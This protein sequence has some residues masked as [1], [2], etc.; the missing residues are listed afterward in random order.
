MSNIKHLF[1]RILYIIIFLLGSLNVMGQITL[2]IKNQPLKKVI[3]Q[4]EKV[5]EYRFFYNNDLAD[6]NKSVTLVAQNSNIETVLK[7][8]ASQTSFSYLIKPNFQIVLSD[9][10]PS[11]QTKLQDITGRV[12]DA[13]GIPIIG[14]NVIVKGTTNGVITDIDGNFS[15]EKVPVK[16]LLQ[17]SYIGYET[18]ELAVALGKT[19]VKVVM[20]ENSKLLNEVVVT[21]FGLAQ[22]KATLTGAIASVG[23]D[24]ISRSSAVNTSGALV[25]K[26]AGLNYRSTDSRPGNATTLQIRNMGTPLFVIDGVQSDEGQFNNIDFNDIES[27]S[28]LKDAS[29]SIYGVRAANGVIVVT[30]KKGQKNSKSTV[31]LNTYYGIQ[32]VSRLQKPADAVTYVENYIQSETIQGKTSRLYNKE[33]LEKW[34]QGTE[35]GY[36]PFDWYDYIWVTSPQYYVNA[37]V[38]GG[39]DKINYYF[40]LGHMNQESAIRNYGGMKRY[41]IQMNI[42][43]QITDKFKIGMNMNGRIK[44]LK[45]PGVPGSDDYSNPTAATYRNLPTVRPFANDN[46]NYPASVGSDSGLN[47]GLLNFEK[48]GVFEDTWRMAQLNLNA[49]YEIIKGLKAKALFG[50]YFASELLNNQEYTYRVYR[51]DEATDEYVDV[52]GR[53]SAWRERTNAQVEELTSNIQLAYDKSFGEHSINAIVGFEAIKR[54][55]PKS[56]LHAIPASNSLHLI[57]YDTI[58]KFDDTGNNTQAR[59]GWLGRFNYNYANKYLVDFSA[60]Y[61]GSWKFPPNHRWGFFPSASLGWRISEE[62]FWKES[63]IASVF[64]DLKIRGSYGLVGDDNVDGYNAFD[65]MTGYDYKQGGGVIDGSYIIGTTPRNLPVTT[66]SWAKAKI[67]DIGIDVA[68]FNNRLSGSVDFFRRIKTGI[69]ASRDDVLLPEE[70]GFERPKENLNSNVHIGYDLFARWNDKV[71]EFSYSVSANFTYSRFYNWEQYNPKFSNS[72]DEYRNSKWHRFGNINWA[73]ESDGQFQ[74][75]EEIASWPIDNDQKGNTTLRPGDIKYVDQNGDGIINDMDKRPI[76]YREDSTPVLNFGLNLACAWKGFDLA[77][78]FSGAGMSTWNPGA[79]Q[80]IP[81][82]NNGNNPAYYMEDT[83]RLSD[84]FD[85][86][87]ELIPGKYPTLLIGNNANNHSN[88][89]DSSFWKYNV[90]Y[91]KLRNLEVGYTF[92]KEWL[93]RCKISNL[94]IYLAGQ[95]LFTLTNVPIDPEVSAAN[96][97]AY[98]TMRIINLGL[99]LKF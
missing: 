87:S 58:D 91:L 35:K 79:I 83:W 41:N 14:A 32:H 22:K 48:S 59:L 3:K 6:L 37:N 39:S 95:N 67:M 66:L 36:V 84:I 82:N 81:F 7:K 44:S 40:S 54:D 9:D 11:Q 45:N 1:S 93:Q 27:I 96:G 30:T 53:A 4:I 43:A 90:R 62:N 94:R 21:G 92:P 98:P 85:A 20:T 70:V 31:T 99:T 33:D 19:N 52:G 5:S 51:Y 8:L 56:W 15:L 34:R 97:A 73:F 69:P 12:I 29:A 47:F 2:T 24:D 80:K 42:E 50:Y 74:S 10:I 68:F 28:I 64:N 86:N 25:G 77:L 60:R 72:W 18:K 65:Y 75:W 88:Y 55:A 89:K 26:I 17:I 46:P 38:S 49:E 57:Y 78:D 61:D 71:N 76:G 63:K 16:S 13:T 23:A